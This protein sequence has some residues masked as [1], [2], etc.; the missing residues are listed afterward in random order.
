LGKRHI[1][2]IKDRMYQRWSKLCR[3]ST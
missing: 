3:G 2:A 1:I